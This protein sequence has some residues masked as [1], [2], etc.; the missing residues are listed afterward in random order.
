MYICM[1]AYSLTPSNPSSVHAPKSARI[2]MLLRSKVLLGY[3]KALRHGRKGPSWSHGLLSRTLKADVWALAVLLPLWPQLPLNIKR[4]HTSAP[5]PTRLR[6]PGIPFPMFALLINPCLLFKICSRM[7]FSTAFPHLHHSS[8]CT[9]LSMPG[10]PDVA[11]GLRD[12]VA[13]KINTLRTGTAGLSDTCTPGSKDR[14]W[15]QSTCGRCSWS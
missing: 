1:C 6:L 7:T 4:P 13:Q 8:S 14:T 11:T 2:Q 10:T 12:S 15:A 9:R 3:A 5:W